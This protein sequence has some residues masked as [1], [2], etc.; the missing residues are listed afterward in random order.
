MSGIGGLP[1]VPC[2]R[3]GN[4]HAGPCGGLPEQSDSPRV[5]CIDCGTHST[6]KPDGWQATVIGKATVWVC[7][8]CAPARFGTGSRSTHPRI[9]GLPPEHQR[10]MQLGTRR[11]HKN[12]GEVWRL[13]EVLDD[14]QQVC[15]LLSRESDGAERILWLS[16]WLSEAWESP[17][18]RAG[19]R[20][21]S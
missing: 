8:D 4:H 12:S 14:R 9:T 20:S 15:V 2:P 10:Y 1:G 13:I 21:S 11:L 7:A 3:C 16:H 18:T 6:D 17:K 19:A 5:L